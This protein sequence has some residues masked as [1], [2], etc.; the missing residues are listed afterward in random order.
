MFD[1]LYWEKPFKTI[2]MY[3][4]FI[5]VNQLVQALEFNISRYM[6]LIKS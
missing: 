2:T 5:L 1:I 3:I 6:R 4:Y